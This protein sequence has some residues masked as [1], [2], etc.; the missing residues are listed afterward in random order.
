MKCLSFETKPWLLYF[1]YACIAVP[2]GFPVL[3]LFGLFC[4]FRSRKYEDPYVTLNADE[5]DDE[6]SYRLAADEILETS[7]RMS[8]NETTNFALKFLHENYKPSCWYWEVIEMY[9]KLLLT[10]VLTIFASESKIILAVAIMLSSFFTILHAYAK[11][12]KNSFENL[13]QLIS[14]SVIPLNLCIG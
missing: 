7:S 12:I 8:R 11:P 14:L 5:C 9:R 2:V 3:L 6:Q 13:L 4:L 1:V 10:S